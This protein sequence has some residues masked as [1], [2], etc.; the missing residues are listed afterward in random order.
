MTIWLWPEGLF[1]RRMTLSFNKMTFGQVSHF[2]DQM[3]VYMGM[4]TFKHNADEEA[5]DTSLDVSM[6][7]TETEDEGKVINMSRLAKWFWCFLAAEW[8]PLL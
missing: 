7:S 1:T 6:Q 3:K 2:V 4:E 8:C 5:L